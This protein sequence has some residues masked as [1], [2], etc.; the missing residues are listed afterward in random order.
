VSFREMGNGLFVGA[1]SRLDGN[2][3][4][5]FWATSLVL[6]VGGIGVIGSILGA[7]LLHNRGPV[8][9]I[10]EQTLMVGCGVLVAAPVVA[11]TDRFVLRALADVPESDSSRYLP[12]IGWGVLSGIG[13]L[14]A[15]VVGGAVLDW[16]DADC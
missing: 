2:W 5:L 4:A 9:G 3:G 6:I 16:S 8:Y 14:G 7:I 10:S 15:T 13:V 11:V 1:F 12:I